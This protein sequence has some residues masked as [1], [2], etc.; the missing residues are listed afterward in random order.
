M[1]DYKTFEA[2]KFDNI[3]HDRRSVSTKK[4]ESPQED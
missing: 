1:E 2:V 4:I 3:N